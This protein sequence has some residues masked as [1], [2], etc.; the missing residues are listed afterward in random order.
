MKTGFALQ[1]DLGQFRL[2]QRSSC[3]LMPAL[4]ESDLIV[5]RRNDV[6]SL[7]DIAPTARGIALERGCLCR[8]VPFHCRGG[9]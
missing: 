5:A 7:A 4:P 8:N 2:S 3:Y 1:S 6:K 9:L